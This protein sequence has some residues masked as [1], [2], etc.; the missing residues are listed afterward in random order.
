MISVSLNLSTYFTTSLVVKYLCTKKDFY[1]E[2]RFTTRIA[3][4]RAT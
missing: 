3:T 1:R 4:G 2:L